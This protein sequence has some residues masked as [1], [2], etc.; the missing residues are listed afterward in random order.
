MTAEATPFDALLTDVGRRMKAAIPVAD[1]LLSERL[2]MA[3]WRG[4]HLLRT[5]LAAS[6]GWEPAGLLLY[7]RSDVMGDVMINVVDTMEQRFTSLDP[8]IQM[9]IATDEGTLLRP[10]VVAGRSKDQVP[11]TDHISTLVLL[12]EAGW[13]LHA[14]PETMLSCAQTDTLEAAY[15]DPSNDDAFVCRLA[16]GLLY[17]G[18]NGSGRMRESVKERRL[19]ILLDSV[20]T[21]TFRPAALPVFVW[22]QEVVDC[23]RETYKAKGLNDD[24]VIQRL[25]TCR[26]NNNYTEWERF[27][28][29]QTIRRILDEHTPAERA[30]VQLM[31]N[32]DIDTLTS[33]LPRGRSTVYID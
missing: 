7:H 17:C 3:E 11:V 28:V 8:H 1:G 15:L 32:D 16:F 4:L 24:D 33:G 23:L 2:R 18:Y 6:K 5:V 14:I 27:S 10:C 31:Y 30:F 29:W 22:R 9:R 26:P 19:E 13:P 12:A 20:R 21:D 25:L